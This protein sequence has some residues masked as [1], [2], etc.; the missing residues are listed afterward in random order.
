MHLFGRQCLLVVLGGMRKTYA[1]QY[2]GILAVW[3]ALKDAYERGYR[4][5]EFMDVGL[6]FK[7]TDIV[8]SFFVRRKTKQHTPLVPFQMDMAE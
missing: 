7:N 8:N 5:L 1:L 3:M 2:P 4:H 6:P